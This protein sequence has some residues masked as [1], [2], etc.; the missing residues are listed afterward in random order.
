VAEEI[1]TAK[2]GYVLID[3][4]HDRLAVRRYSLSGQFD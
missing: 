2:A 3:K 4:G 1:V